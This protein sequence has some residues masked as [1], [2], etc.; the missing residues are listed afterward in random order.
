MLALHLFAMDARAALTAELADELIE[1]AKTKPAAVRTIRIS[2]EKGEAVGQLSLA[3]LYANGL[4][5]PKD[6][7]QAVN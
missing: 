5:V 1:A 6:D 7:V 3:L 2:A 4:G